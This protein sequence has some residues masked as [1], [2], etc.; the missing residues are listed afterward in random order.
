MSELAAAQLSL[1]RDINAGAVGNP[2]SRAIQ[3]ELNALQRNWQKQ[4]HEARTQEEFIAVQAV[5]DH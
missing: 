5:F 2:E 4:L 3:K 1:L